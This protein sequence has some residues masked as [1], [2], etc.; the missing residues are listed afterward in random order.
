MK[1]ER[2]PANTRQ[3]LAEVCELVRTQMLA[4]CE[5]YCAG[6]PWP[7]DDARTWPV[8]AGNIDVR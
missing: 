7:A 8:T 4:R 6:R 5:A 3:N 2:R 1:G